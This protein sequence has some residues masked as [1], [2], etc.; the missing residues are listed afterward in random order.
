MLP[1]LLLA[2]TATSLAELALVLLAPRVEEGRQ[3]A[4]MQPL[5]ET[6]PVA[7]DNDLLAD[8]TPLNGLPQD[9]P[10][11]VYRARRG[12]EPVGAVVAP[13]IARGYNGDLVLAVG[14]ARDGTLTG[15]RVLHHHETPGLGDQ[16]HQDRSRWLEQLPGHSLADTDAADWAVKPDG[17]RFDAISGATVTP[18]GLLRAV[19][20]VLERYAADP[21][22]FY[23]Q[24]DPHQ[25][26]QREPPGP[27][28]N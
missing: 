5:F 24:D 19:H 7:H 14:I 20:A 10:A 8:H 2:V 11:T 26:G 15:V 18:R 27:A 6:M 13:V 22:S 23:R 3:R 21:D 28:R 1:V 17:G 12:G 25:S 16:V 4:A 9:E